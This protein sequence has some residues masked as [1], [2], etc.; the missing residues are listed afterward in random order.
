LAGSNLLYAGVQE[1]TPFYVHALI[2][3]SYLSGAYK[4]IDGGSQIAIQMSKVIVSG[5]E[6]YKHKKVVSANYN[7]Q[8]KYHGSSTG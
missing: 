1:K 7:E 4:F 5:G 8:A 2:M 3:K 6:I